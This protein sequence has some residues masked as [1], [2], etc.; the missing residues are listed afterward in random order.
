MPVV[1]CL[2]LSTLG[3]AG[4]EQ[5]LEDPDRLAE[6][7]HRQDARVGTPRYLTGE[8][9]K[10]NLWEVPKSP[11]PNERWVVDDCVWQAPRSFITN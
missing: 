4:G 5:G 3:M 8:D 11:A 7:T 6:H 10:P 9:L 1:E 2:G